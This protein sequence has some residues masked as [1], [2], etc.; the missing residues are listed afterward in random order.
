MYHAVRAGKL[1]D[2]A[3][4]AEPAALA[5]PTLQIVAE[6]LRGWLTAWS[7]STPLPESTATTIREQCDSIVAAGELAKCGVPI[8]RAVLVVLCVLCGASAPLDAA[9]AASVPG[10]AEGAL[11]SLED[12][13]WFH[14]TLAATQPPSGT[15]RPQPLA[16]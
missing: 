7:P 1:T 15:Y 10:L 16:S 11:A 13:L 9:V 12:W 8:T 2:A 5:L 4:A 3:A 14:C 6:G